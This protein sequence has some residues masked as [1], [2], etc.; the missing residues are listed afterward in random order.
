MIKSLSL[1]ELLHAVSDGETQRAKEIYGADYASQSEAF[2][3]LAEEVQEAGEEHKEIL[4]LVDHLLRFV[5]SDYRDGIVDRLAVMREAALREAEESIQV[6]AVCR[7]WLDMM[8]GKE[9]EQ[10]C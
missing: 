9:N 3:V 2:G 6:A 5:R 1:S 8:K 4:T 10:N 7:K